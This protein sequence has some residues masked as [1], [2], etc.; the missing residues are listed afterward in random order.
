MSTVTV[1][2]RGICC[3]VDPLDDDEKQKFT[4]RVLLPSSTPHVHMGMEEHQTIIEFYADDLDGKPAGVTE[5][6][7]MRPGDP[8]HYKNIR[9]EKPTLIELL[10]VPAGG[11]Q[12][13]RNFGTSVIHF[14]EVLSELPPLKRSLVGTAAKINRELVAAVV[15]LP[16]GELSAGP[17][18]STLTTFNMVPTFAPRYVAQWI[19]HVIEVDGPLAIRLTE[20]GEGGQDPRIIRFKNTTQLITI[21][22]EPERLTVGHFVPHAGM[23]GPSASPVQSS[24]HFDLYYDLMADPPVRPRPA[25]SLGLGGGCNPANRP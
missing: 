11:I 12:S 21:G 15:D 20:L 16:A 1:R 3:F 7:Y 18:E 13:S 23:H 8:G 6:Y 24:G 2:F 5:T 10:G 9:L 17:A 22:N 19:Q 14:K 4:K 25:P